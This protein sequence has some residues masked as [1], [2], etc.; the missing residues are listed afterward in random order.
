MGVRAR[1]EGR[2]PHDR[3]TT[4]S[5][6]AGR[7]ARTTM[8]PRRRSEAACGGAKALDRQP[9]AAFVGRRHRLH[10]GGK[11]RTGV[12]RDSRGGSI[13]VHDEPDVVPSSILEIL[14][15][16][17]YDRRSIEKPVG[18]DAGSR[19]AM[20]SVRHLPSR[21]SKSNRRSALDREAQHDDR[22]ENVSCTDTSPIGR[23]RPASTVSRPRN[24]NVGGKREKHPAARKEQA[25]PTRS[26]GRGRHVEHDAG[27]ERGGTTYA[28]RRSR[29]S[30][31]TSTT[32]TAHGIHH[33]APQFRRIKAEQVAEVP[34]ARGERRR[35][36]A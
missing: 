28:T 14:A 10:R 26:L 12:G 32:S 20:A 31:T 29:S 25:E 24:H 15:A 33:A 22:D 16:R 34:T 27:H 11:T 3:S 30:A 23:H 9:R 5:P 13:H 4:S 1:R 7:R 19:K 36:R 8:H 2:A 17:T 35:T 21:A 18:R 6:I